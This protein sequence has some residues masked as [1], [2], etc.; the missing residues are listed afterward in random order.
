MSSPRAQPRT[1]AALQDT[2]D[3]LVSGMGAALLLHLLEVY[4]A[5][6]TNVALLKG[7]HQRFFSKAFDLE[8]HPYLVR[9]EQACQTWPGRGTSDDVRR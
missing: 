9:N 8:L 5:V 2:P 3:A 1:L 4:V 6:A 7:G